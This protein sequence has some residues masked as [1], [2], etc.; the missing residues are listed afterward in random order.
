MATHIT[1]FEAKTSI[2]VPG[3]DVPILA[4]VKSDVAEGLTITL[5]PGTPMYML[6]EQIANG[7]I[8]S[9]CFMYTP[10]TQDRS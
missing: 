9:V 3:V 4:V 1:A 6:H 5:E 7:Q 8:L 2:Q 10:A